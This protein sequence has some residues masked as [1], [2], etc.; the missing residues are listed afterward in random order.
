MKKIHLAAIAAAVLLATSCDSL[1]FGVDADSAGVNPYIYGN[2]TVY[3]PP[4]YS[5]WYGGSPW[6]STGW[7]SGWDYGWNRPAWRPRPRPPYNPGVGPVQRPTVTPGVIITPGNV[8]GAGTNTR[9]GNGGLPSA[10]A[11]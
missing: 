10:V 9:P 2:T 4:Y 8:P 3:T 6:W 11:P 7:N 5:D 1:G